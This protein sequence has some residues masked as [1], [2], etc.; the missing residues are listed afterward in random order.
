MVPLP[1]LEGGMSI[2]WD[3]DLSSLK[4]LWPK[5]VCDTGG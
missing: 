3:T 2:P 5:G 4:A 1:K